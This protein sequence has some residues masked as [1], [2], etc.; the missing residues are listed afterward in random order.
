MHNLQ[1]QQGQ[2]GQKE[3]KQEA[4]RVEV[5]GFKYPRLREPNALDRVLSA[6]LW[7]S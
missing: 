1:L 5:A 3:Q 7:G 6:V 2:Q 4:E